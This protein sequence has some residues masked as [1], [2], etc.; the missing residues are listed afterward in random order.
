LRSRADGKEFSLKR[1]TVEFFQEVK[2]FQKIKI[3]TKAILYLI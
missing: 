3:S 1:T 2:I